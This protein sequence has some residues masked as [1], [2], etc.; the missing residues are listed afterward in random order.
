MVQYLVWTSPK[1]LHFRV[2]LF[3]QLAAGHLLAPVANRELRNST[4]KLHEMEDSCN[5][6]KPSPSINDL[7]Q[8][9]TLFDPCAR[10][11]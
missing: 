5:Q 4:K 11:S 10:H 3:Q 9:L 1:Q 8:V 2:L 6:S 7:H